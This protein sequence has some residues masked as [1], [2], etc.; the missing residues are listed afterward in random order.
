MKVNHFTIIAESNVLELIK[1]KFKKNSVVDIHEHLKQVFKLSDKEEGFLLILKERTLDENID[2]LASWFGKLVDDAIS[3]VVIADKPK[4]KNSF[5]SKIQNYVSFVVPEN[6]PDNLFYNVIENALHAM[7][8]SVSSLRL[9]RELTNVYRDLRSV[10]K[11]GQALLTE[12]DF[13]TLLTLIL[14]Q[15]REIVDADGGS[16]YIVEPSGVK[17]Q[18]PTKLRFKKSA[19]HLTADEFLLDI[20]K[21][22]I[23]GYVA[24]IGHHLRINDVYQLTGNEEFHFNPDYD[25]NFNY[26]TKSMML[27]PMKNHHDEVI[28]V[29]Q[30]INKKLDKNRHLTVEEM[31]GRWVIPFTDKCYQIISALAGQAGMAIEN[32]ILMADIR[33]LFDGFVKA[34]VKAI[35]QRDPT[36]S[37]HSAR[38][39]DY[40]ENMARTLDFESSGVFASTR[41]SQDQLRE[42]RYAALLHDF[43]KVGVREKVLVKAKKLYPMELDLIEWRFRYIRKTL[44]KE[45]VEKKFNL[46]KNQGKEALEKM[47]PSL[48]KE[49]HENLDRLKAMF[50]AISKANEPSVLEE[51]DFKTLETLTNK[52]VMLE[53]GIHVPF[54]ERNEFLS[55][56]IKKGTLDANERLEIES[57]VSHTYQFLTQIPWTYDLSNIPDI[58]HGHHEKLD[59]SGYPLGIDEPKISIQTRIMTIADIFDALTAWDRPYK[60]AVPYEHALNILNDEAKHKKIDPDILKIFISAEIYK[61]FQSSLIF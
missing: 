20:N 61:K 53:N 28:G 24:M 26:H 21:N 39:A 58:A 5:D 13:D 9:N 40:T 19:L 30:L 25:K 60:K 45:I 6:I 44:E 4:E 49:F 55:L 43:G 11:V 29:I 37:G 57:H 38:V 8:M 31:K 18:K 32:N 2:F 46:L 16:I 15:A 56:S 35:E 33:N 54:L 12:R 41:F 34:S 36:T 17:G 10:T 3:L 50:D 59:G 23:A 47:E 48:D 52:M 7:Y 51:G 1:T 27:I 22:S 14:N 42:L